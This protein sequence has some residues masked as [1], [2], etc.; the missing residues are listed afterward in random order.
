M[1]RCTSALVSGRRGRLPL[2]LMR[3]AKLRKAITTLLSFGMILRVSSAAVHTPHQQSYSLMQCGA[4]ISTSGFRVTNY[5]YTYIVIY[6]GTDTN[7]KVVVCNIHTAKYVYFLSEPFHL[8]DRN[9][10]STDIV[11]MEKESDCILHEYLL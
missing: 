5:Y 2:M 6:S 4:R 3:G 11:L 9:Q 1:P 7:K 10:S 8:Y